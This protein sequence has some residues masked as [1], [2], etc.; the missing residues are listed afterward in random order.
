[1]TDLQHSA[2]VAKSANRAQGRHLTV[3]G[4]IRTPVLR[5]TMRQGLRQGKGSRH[6]V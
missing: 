2:S 3:S 1:M 5:L 6:P 4:S